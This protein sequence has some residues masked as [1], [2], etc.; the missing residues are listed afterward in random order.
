MRLIGQRD[1]KYLKDFVDTPLQFHI[2]LHYRYKT[3]SYYG[4]IDLDADCVLRGSPEPLYPQV[5]SHPFEK[6]FNTPSVA[7]KLGYQQRRGLD[8]VGK[9]DIS[10]A[11]IGI[12]NY[13]LT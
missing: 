12:Q 10:G 6:E 13:H 8:I 9:E 3:V 7:V 11:V 5:L 1:S 4:T 2:V